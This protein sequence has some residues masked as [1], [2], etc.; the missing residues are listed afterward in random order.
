V[1]GVRE[2]GVAVGP[3]LSVVGMIAG[4]AG[5]LAPTAGALTREAIDLA[6]ILDALRASR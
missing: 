2:R 1:T 6:V 5:A 4:A 3:G